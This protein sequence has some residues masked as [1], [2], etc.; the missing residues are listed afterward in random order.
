VAT[1]PSVFD[2][3]QAL[4]YAPSETYENHA[5]FDTL[6]RWSWREERTVTRKI[7]FKVFVSGYL[8]RCLIALLKH[9]SLA[10]LDGAYVC[11]F[12]DTGNHF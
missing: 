1:Q 7:D 9:P 11:E 6:F 5:Y 8:K 12:N 3:S 10:G 2:T 4:H